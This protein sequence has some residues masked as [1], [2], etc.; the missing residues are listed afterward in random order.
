[1]A[2]SDSDEMTDAELNPLYRH[3]RKGLLLYHWAPASRR[4]GIKRRGLVIGSRHA[5]HSK[6][7]RANYLCF[8]TWPGF[9][10]NYSAGTTRTRQTWDLYVI[11]AEA[12]PGRITWRQD[13]KGQTPAELRAWQ[14]IPAEAVL[15]IAS[16]EHKP[17]TRKK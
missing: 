12:V 9:A 6:G 17:R 3:S 4:R 2:K 7:W 1:M 13:H 14:D 10:W 8:G 15:Y 16:R 11:R 5:T